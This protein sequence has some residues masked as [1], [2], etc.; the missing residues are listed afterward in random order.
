MARNVAEG[1]TVANHAWN[2]ENLAGM[3]YSSF[4]DTIG[5]TQAVLSDRAS[6]CLRPPYGSIDAFTR[7]WAM[8]LGLDLVLWTV[9]T[10]DWRRPGAQ[11]IADRIVR[12][13]TDEAIVLMHD[14]GGNRTQTVE[15]LELALDRLSGRGL[16]F[17]PVCT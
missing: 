10:N 17:E 9:D 5:R 7:E 14:G 16:R 8:A 15:G 3:S 6:P 13:A 12:G 2:H 11:V 4:D 1:D